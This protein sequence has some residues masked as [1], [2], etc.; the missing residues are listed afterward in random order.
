MAIIFLGV[1]FL[2]VWFPLFSSYTAVTMAVGVGT[3]LV[4]CSAAVLFGRDE[5]QYDK[6]PVF[7]SPW[8]L[9]VYKYKSGK[10]DIDTHKTP[11]MLMLTCC[12]FMLGWG[13]FTTVCVKP[14]WIGVCITI[15]AEVLILQLSLYL[16]YSGST[17]REKVKDFI[18]ELVVKQAWLDSKTNFVNV[19]GINKRADYVS[20]EQWW[21]RRFHLTNYIRAYRGQSW[22]MLPDRDE[23]HVDKTELET[24][25]D[26]KEFHKLKIQEWIDA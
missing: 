15:I 1:L 12:V 22:N 3:L 16:I 19:L 18:D 17:R 21:K 20:Y 7:Y 2:G 13:V 9:P 23:F 8:L 4:G 10:N 11:T 26:K 25:P 6:D 14:I 5:A 24:A